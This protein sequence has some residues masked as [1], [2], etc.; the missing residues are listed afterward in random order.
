MAID[1]DV[2]FGGV[3]Y[4]PCVALAAL[5]PAYM[6]MMAG[7]TEAEIRFRDRTTKFMPGDIKQ[8]GM[9]I[10][11]LESQCAAQSGRP[12]RRFAITAMPR[13]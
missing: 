5:R 13:S 3:D 12:A 4:D 8:L 11:S 6:Q 10:N 9:L 1:Y 2:I 7:G